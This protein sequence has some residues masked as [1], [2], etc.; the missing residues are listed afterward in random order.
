LLKPEAQ[1]L[2]RWHHRSARDAMLPYTA[3]TATDDL[4]LR[5]APRVR[6]SSLQVSTSRSRVWCATLCRWAH[7]TL[8]STGAGS[9]KGDC[10]LCAEKRLLGVRLYRQHQ[11][12]LGPH[13]YSTRSLF[14]LP[15][16]GLPPLVLRRVAYWTN[17]PPPPPLP[18]WCWVRKVDTRVRPWPT[19][20]LRTPGAG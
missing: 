19:V 15:H 3:P 6:K 7:L 14:L 17:T 11:H 10:V 2:L 13:L 12:I 8:Y 1:G 16:R 4:V 5:K 18:L 20:C 9:V